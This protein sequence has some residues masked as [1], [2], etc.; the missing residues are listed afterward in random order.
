MSSHIALS[1]EASSTQITF[2]RFLSSMYS[3]V[4][5]HL[6]LGWKSLWTETASKGSVLLGNYYIC[7][8]GNILN[9][10][11]PTVASYDV[12]LS[13]DIV[14]KQF[15]PRTRTT[16]YRSWSGSKPFDTLIAFLKVLFEKVNLSDNDKSM[17]NYTVHK[18]FT[19]A[20]SY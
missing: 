19:K 16:N 10:L 5:H 3:L 20:G 2:V 1:I 14:W 9:P 4:S 17:K 8:K 6:V 11:P 13:A 15:G 12:Y 7:N 18:E